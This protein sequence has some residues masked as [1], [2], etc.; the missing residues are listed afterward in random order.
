MYNSDIDVGILAS[1]WKL[2]HSADILLVDLGHWAVALMQ[3]SMCNK[4]DPM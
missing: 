3:T 2:V 1:K 4:D